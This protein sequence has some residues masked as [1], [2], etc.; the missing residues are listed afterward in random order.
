MSNKFAPT[1]VTLLK[2]GHRC[3]CAR[4]VL[5]AAFDNAIYAKFSAFANGGWACESTARKSIVS[6]NKILTKILW[7]C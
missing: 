5:D 2:S 4:L 3:H 7:I 1:C 6:P